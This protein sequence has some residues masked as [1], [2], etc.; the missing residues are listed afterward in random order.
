MPNMAPNQKLNQKPRWPPGPLRS[1]LGLWTLTAP[2]GPSFLVL[3]RPGRTEVLKVQTELAG[4]ASP[5]GRGGPVQVEGL[6]GVDIDVDGWCLRG[7][8]RKD[9]LA[10]I[11]RYH[12]MI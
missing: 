8:E 5:M 10:V 2:D 9:T 6:R 1:V 11:I 3:S 12:N 7:S 4:A